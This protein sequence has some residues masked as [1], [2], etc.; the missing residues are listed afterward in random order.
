MITP[1]GYLLGLYCI[2]AQKNKAS[3]D[4]KLMF[5]EH[6]SDVRGLFKIVLIMNFNL[7]FPKLWISSHSSQNHTDLDPEGTKFGNL[8]GMLMER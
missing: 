1:D 3:N 4:I 6:C 8:A 2:S 5:T 7:L